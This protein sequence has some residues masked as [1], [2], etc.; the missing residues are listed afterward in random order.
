MTLNC[1]LKKNSNKKE[2]KSRVGE[3]HFTMILPKADNSGRRIKPNIHKKYI[4]RVN[5][6]FGGSTVKPITLGCWKDGKRRRL[7]CE[8]GYAVETFRDFD[9]SSQTKKL[10]SVQRKDVLKKDH[11]KMKSIA[12]SAAKEYGQ[13]SVPVIYDNISDVTLV[14]GKWRPQISSSKT[15]NKITN[16]DVFERNI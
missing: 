16:G 15:G 14:K 9:S 6:H 10:N 4:N 3:A 8:T 1:D 2:C 13:D 11:A 5:E 7:Q 12:K